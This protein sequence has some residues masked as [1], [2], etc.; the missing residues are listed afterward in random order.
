MRR[1]L[2]NSLLVAFCG[3]L[4]LTSCG[5]KKR[6]DVISSKKFEAI[7]YDYHL[8]QVMVNDLP[9]SERY[10]KD[11]Y[12]NYVYTKHGITEA[13]IDTSLVYYSRHP[14]RLAEIYSNLS[15]RIENEI[16]LQEND[17]PILNKHEAR[18]VVG[19][20]ANLW[21]DKAF[22]ELSP[23]PFSNKYNFTIPTDTNFW[24]H[25]TIRWQ[26]KII[27]MRDVT[28]STEKY[29]HIDL[30]VKY[31]NDSLLTA[32][33]L[34]HTSGDF[35]LQVADSIGWMIKSI[36]GTAYL[37]STNAFDRMLLINPQLM[38][39]HSLSESLG[40]SDSTK[41]VLSDSIQQELGLKLQSMQQAAKR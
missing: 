38:R 20:S 31:M 18:E 30:R 32:D 7:L 6:F 39:Y 5:E 33:T 23:S 12:F 9:T 2:R 34:L 35:S 40:A 11:L 41:K 36:N 16:K 28:D 14:K 25:D 8:A 17:E 21:Y 4:F 37:K 10:Q 15:E 24:L 27:L 1:M 13:Q 29:V 19:D 22:V 3:L 26:G